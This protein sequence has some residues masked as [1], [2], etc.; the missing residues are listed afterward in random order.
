MLTS[1][2]VHL[3]GIG[4][5]SEARLWQ[6][7][8]V[9]WPR[10]L[11]RAG[12]L[13]LPQ[14]KVRRWAEEIRESLSRLESED[15]AY[16]AA[17][18]ASRDQWRAWPQFAHR[19]A[20]L[21]IETTGASTFDAVTVIGLYDG[22]E[23][24][25][26]VR[27]R[28]LD[29]FPE[30]VRRCSLLVT[31]FGAGFDLPVLRRTFPEVAFDHLHVDLCFLLKRLGYSG[32]LKRVET[33]LGIGRSARTRGLSGWDAVRLWNEYRRGSWEA[34]SLLLRYNEEDVLHLQPL[35][36]FAY[37]EMYSRARSGCEALPPMAEGAA[38]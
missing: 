32:G 4:Y 3:Q 36:D 19:A 26:F 9:D 14:A 1:T 24:R 5:A 34:L 6:S 25:Q 16:F 12:A 17:R 21:D 22:R 13:P 28:N 2:F 15:H 37:R 11:D 35:L 18:L 29:A 7:G 33:Q 10:F 30:A 31:F 27:G 8:A 38:P 23:M 20:F